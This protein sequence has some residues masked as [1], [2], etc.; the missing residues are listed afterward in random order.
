MKLYIKFLI[1]MSCSTSIV[2]AEQLSQEKYDALL[3]QYMQTIQNTKIILDAK[4][5]M[6]TAFQKNKAFCERMSAYENIKKISEQ[7]KQLENASIMLVA[8][9][10]YLDR[11]NKNLEMSGFSGFTFCKN[12]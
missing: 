2:Y 7:N 12:K 6:A 4:D 3:N 8:A 9:N 1:M 11:Q 5:T 10:F